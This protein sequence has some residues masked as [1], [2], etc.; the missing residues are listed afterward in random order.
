MNERLL[1]DIIAL[2]KQI[3]AQTE[4]ERQRSAAWRERELSHLDAAEQAL[5]GQR[6]KQFHEAI[7]KAETALEQQAQDQIEETGRL[8]QQLATLSAE[9]LKSL[10]RDLLVRILPEPVD[11]HTNGQN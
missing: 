3:Q 10:V 4:I 11:D 9:E 2:E 1:D 5:R 6:D 8:C 7:N